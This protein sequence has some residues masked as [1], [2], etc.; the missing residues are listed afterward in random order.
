M[1]YEYTFLAYDNIN[2]NYAFGGPIGDYKGTKGDMTAVLNT[3]A[4][5]GWR[6]HTYHPDNPRLWIFLLE[7]MKI[8]TVG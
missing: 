6:V 5:E 4:A 8:E 2:G 7:R 1:N 3:F